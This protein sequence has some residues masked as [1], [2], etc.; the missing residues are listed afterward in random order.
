MQTELHALC[1]VF[2]LELL[3]ASDNDIST[4]SDTVAVFKTLT[5]LHTVTL[6][7]NRILF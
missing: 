5:L 1:S 7:V 6:R 3:D 2:G 4:I